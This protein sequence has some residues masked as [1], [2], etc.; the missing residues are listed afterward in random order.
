MSTENL[1]YLPLTSKFFFDEGI[2]VKRELVAT[3]GLKWTQES[4][5]DCGVAMLKVASEMCGLLSK[6]AD[7]KLTQNNLIYAVDNEAVHASTRQLGYKVRGA[8]ASKIKV[9]ITTTAA[10][11]LPAGAKLE[12]TLEDGTKI[13][14]ELLDE[15]IF[16][17]A[18][19]KYAY[20]LQGETFTTTFT[21]DNLAFQSFVIP[22]YPIAYG[23][24]VFAVGS[25]VWTEVI[26]FVNSGP[27][28]KHFVLEYD[29][30][31]QPTVLLGDGVFGAKAGSGA[32]VTIAYRTCDGAQGNVAPGEMNFVSRFASVASVT[33]EAPSKAVLVRGIPVT[34]VEIE[35]VD[36]GSISSFRDSGVAY[37]DSDSFTYTGITGNKFT[38]VT[39]LENVH[40]REEEVTY[41]TT[42]TYGQ[43]KETSKQSKV[44]ALRNNRIKSSANSVLDYSYLANQVAGVARTKASVAYNIVTLQLVPADGGLPSASL[45]ASVLEYMANRKNATHTL[46]AVDPNYVFVDVV[47]EVTPGAG[48]SYINDVKP[49]VIEEIQN[50]LNPLVK[51]SASSYYLN[52]WGNLLKKN[53]VES[54]I[55]G[56]YNRALVADVEITSFKKSTDESGDSNIQLAENEIAQIGKIIVKRKGIVFALPA[57]ELGGVTGAQS[58]PQLSRNIV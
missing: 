40:A 19:S 41:S 46:S 13:K 54:N 47:C 2:R 20:A 9:Q 22:Q 35:V 12:K 33:N 7:N 37:I 26:D 51:D 38:G 36:D 24:V 39:G 45:K 6:Q 31:G 27:D 8:I 28:D 57:G 21:G 58:I 3:E 49:V 56:L 16:T 15:T 42:F 34:S 29:F 5:S 50:Y 53:L 1:G 14:F 17:G 18:G 52:G 23:G 32:V 44:S 55:F 43:N 25:N 10:Q 30:T 11:T 4:P 48:Y